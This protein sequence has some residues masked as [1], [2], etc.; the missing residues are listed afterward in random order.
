MEAY[1]AKWLT[2]LELNPRLSRCTLRQGT[3]LHFVSLYPGVLM[4]TRDIL[5]G[6]GGGNPAM[7]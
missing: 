6:G 7:D 4:G 1:V 5:L 3:L 2:H